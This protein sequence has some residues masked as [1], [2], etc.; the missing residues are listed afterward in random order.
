M[1]ATGCLHQRRV[2]VLVGLLDS[3]AALL[4]EQLHYGR[5]VVLHGVVQ[6]RV[7]ARRLGVRVGT[8]LEQEG[9]NLRVAVRARLDQRRGRL[10]R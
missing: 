9:G 6:R 7:A 3:Q 1:P 8:V 5:I 10:G 4:H 2:A